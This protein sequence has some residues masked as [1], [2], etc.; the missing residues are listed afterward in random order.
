[1]VISAIL[2]MVSLTTIMG[3]ISSYG[4]MGVKIILNKGIIAHNLKKS[5]ENR[6][7]TQIST[8]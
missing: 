2:I 6:I 7:D 1:M 4:A 8:F 3:L 5:I